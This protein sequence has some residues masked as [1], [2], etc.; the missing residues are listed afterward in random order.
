MSFSEP[1]R[2]VSVHQHHVVVSWFRLGDWW[3]WGGGRAVDIQNTPELYSVFLPLPPSDSCLPGCPC[4]VAVG[5]ASRRSGQSV[6]GAKAAKARAFKS[7]AFRVV[8]FPLV[9][10]S[11]LLVPQLRYGTCS[12][13]L[14]PFL[15]LFFFSVFS[16]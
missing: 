13:Q 14:P 4:L 16:C 15:A 3:R 2:R 6:W 12:V 9:F 8:V 5:R 1:R 11:K 7:T 10:T